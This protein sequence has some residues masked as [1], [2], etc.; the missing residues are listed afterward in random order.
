MEYSIDTNI[1]TLISL[2]ERKYL[3]TE[4]EYKP[5][6]FAE[7]AQFFTLDIITDIAFGRAFGYLD[8]DSDCYSYVEKTA[9]SLAMMMLVGVFPWM[10]PILHSPLL[11][12]FIPSDKDALGLGKIMR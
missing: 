7:K 1:A 9:E 5:M 12:V 11:R 8:S 3:S 4:T 6:D 10:V 2:I